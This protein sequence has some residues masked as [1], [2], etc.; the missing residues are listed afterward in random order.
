MANVR[1]DSPLTIMCFSWNAAGLRLCETMSQNKADNSRKGFRAFVTKKQP[2]LAPDF[3]EEIRSTINLRQPSLVVMTTQDEANSDT[4]FHSDLLPGSMPE[5]GYSLLKR[6]KLEGV[7]EVSSGAPS[8][9]I[10]TGN[11]KS[12]AIRISI[13]A[14]YDVIGSFRSEEKILSRFFG[15]D[16]QVNSTCEQLDRVSGAIATYVWHETYGKFA[17]I[18]THLPSGMTSLKVG[19][20]LDYASYRVAT[21]ASNSLCL[22]KLYNQLVSSLP[23]ES[24]PDHI[25]LLGDLNFDIVI[26]GKKN[27]EVISELASN[28]TASKL[29]DL[30]RYDELKKSIDD[31]PLM[32]FKEGVA[33][34]GPLFMPTWRLARGRPDSCAPSRDITRI[35]TSCFSE[36]NEALGGL[37]W[38]DRVLYKEMM[39]SNYI[40]H[41]TDYNRIDVRNMHASTHA[42]VTAFF[43]MRS[44]Q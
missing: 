27:I 13:Y 39:T 1:T 23:A 25:F 10:P 35:D 6:D 17:F 15:N 32:G 18:A 7:G 11:P 2:C 19:N 37:G 29:R 40:A 12:N 3:F 41:C 20:G 21:R 4:Y 26:P 44:I 9:R 30:Q 14:R 42:G 36:P 22:L 8:I 31:V 5:I 33:G 34:E 16:G 43:E 28:V 24:R 38:H